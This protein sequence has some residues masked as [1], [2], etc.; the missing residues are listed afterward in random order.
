MSHSPA[1]QPAPGPRPADAR[2]D[3][4]AEEHREEGYQGPATLVVGD[5]EVSVTVDLRGHFQPI[6][7]FYRWYG[8]VVADPEVTRAL[9]GRRAA[10]TVRTPEG[11]ARG[12]AAD[13]DF[14]GRYRVTG[15]S[16]PPFRT[17]GFST[18]RTRP[19]GP[20]PAGPAPGADPV[21]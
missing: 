6:D 2:H 21:R 1:T 15:T 3:A 7:G 8:R 19:C 10:V 4:P 12:E 14:W 9:G 5:T 18:V 17:V 20:G 16:R 13:P 11:E